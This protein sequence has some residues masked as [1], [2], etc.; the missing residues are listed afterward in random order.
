MRTRLRILIALPV[1]ALLLAVGYVVGINAWLASEHFRTLINPDDSDVTIEF[2]SAHSYI[3]GRVT[4]EDLVITARHGDGLEWRATFGEAS[5]GIGL[6]S[7]MRNG[8]DL[9]GARASNVTLNFRSG[10]LSGPAADLQPPIPPKATKAPPPDDD[11]DDWFVRVDDLRVEQMTDMW[12][13]EYHYQG[14]ASLVGSL[15]VAVDGALSVDKAQLDLLGGKVSRGT[16]EGAAV[17]KATLAMSLPQIMPSDTDS[18][19]FA[20]VV[21][22]SLEGAATVDNA[23]VLNVYL[24]ETPSLTIGGGSGRIEVDLDFRG[25]L[26]TDG[27]SLKIASEDLSAEL[28]GQSAS[29]RGDVSLQVTGVDDVSRVRVAA[30][31]Q[32]FEL[33]RQGAKTGGVHGKGLSLVVTMPQMAPGSIPEDWRVELDLPSATITDATYLG[34]F[35]PRGTGFAVLSGRGTI[36]GKLVVTARHPEE[37][38]GYVRARAKAVALRYDESKFS[39]DVDIDVKINAVNLRKSWLDVSGSQLALT[40]VASASPEQTGAGWWGKL[41]LPRANMT[42]GDAASV[43]GDVRL[44]AK[45]LRPLVAAFAGEGTIAKW[46]V[47]LLAFDGLTASASLKADDNRFEVDEAKAKA[48]DV[49]LDGW[50]RRRAKTRQGALLVNYGALTFGVQ[51]ENDDVDLKIIGPTAWYKKSKAAKKL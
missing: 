25:G 37:D 48:T 45:S 42:V 15:L 19:T 46:G 28:L 3:P 32:E 21:K 17:E 12:I 40:N 50:F 26:L 33:K 20:K 9:Q 47:N 2:R 10:R 31:F 1:V 5:L 22:A 23:S 11:S 8:I 24:R 14:Q 6:I 29:G 41:A 30:V 4:A 27:S 35:L 38:Q 44:E 43:E 34:S 13:D 16:V 51:L 7:L 49:S 18:L 36:E 39:G